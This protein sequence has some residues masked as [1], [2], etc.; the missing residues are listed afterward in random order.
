MSLLGAQSHFL[1]DSGA[2]EAIKNSQH[3]IHSMSLIHK[4]LYQ[5]DNI[6][7]INVELYFKELIEYYKMAFDTRERIRFEVD[8]APLEL[9]SAQ[10]VPMGLILNEAVNNALKHAFPNEA[11]GLIQVSLLPDADTLI[12]KVKDNGVGMPNAQTGF[13]SLGLNLIS[14]FSRE[15]N[16]AL[17]I[18]GIN[19]VE[20]TVTFKYSKPAVA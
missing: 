11:T 17:Q 18:N 6:V 7:T 2:K 13:N 20:I 4:K 19:G 9:E 15:L 14:G 16:A 12:F 5:S 8:V 3:R 10:A 1:E